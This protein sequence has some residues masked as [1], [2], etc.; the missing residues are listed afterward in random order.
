MLK[1]GGREGEV[2][3][4]LVL[5]FISAGGG[6]GGGGGGYPHLYENNYYSRPQ[7]MWPPL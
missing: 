3:Y 7:L 2:E 4:S 5:D 6:G 1:E